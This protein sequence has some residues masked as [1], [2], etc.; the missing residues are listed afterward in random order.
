M[1]IPDP[2]RRATNELLRRA[3]SLRRSMTE[4]ERLLWSKLRH[5]RFAA[6]KFRRQVP[7]GPFIA[8]FVCF[9]SKL[10]I[11]LDGGQHTL[12]REYDADRTRWLEEH[13]LRVVRVWNNELTEIADAVDEMIWRALHEG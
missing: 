11:E 3:R 12:Q 7:L 1:A 5:R 10:I 9:S 2:E 6:F 13:G 8:D 4:P